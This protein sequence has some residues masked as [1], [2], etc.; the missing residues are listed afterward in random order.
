MDRADME[1]VCDDFVRATDRALE[2]SFDVLEIHAGHGYLLGGFISPLSNRRTDEY[3]GS[4]ERRL[5]FPLEV[6]DAVRA[7]WPESLPLSVCLSVHDW[8]RGGLTPDEALEMCR[9]F[10][11]RGADIIH[12]V[13]GQTT[14]DATPHYGRAWETLFSDLI[15]NETGIPTLLGGN[16]TAADEI[17]TVLA[18]GRADLCLASPLPRDPRSLL[19][20]SAYAALLRPAATGR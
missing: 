7:L 11:R 6:F 12:V 17:N 13:T 10:H 15:R 3:G 1:R 16:L 4:L 19:Q 9:V 18:G 14:A 8:S 5:R 20:P 2:A